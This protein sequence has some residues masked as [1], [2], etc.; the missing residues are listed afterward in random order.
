MIKI[1]VVISAFNEEKMIGDCLKSIGTLADEI[2]VVDN[3][4]SDNTAKIAKKYTKNIF[5]VPNDPVMLNKNKNYGFGKTTG[6]WILSLDADER[7]T[8]ELA[9]E[10]KKVTNNKGVNGFEIPRKNIIFGKWIQHSIWWPDYNLR[11]FRKNHGRFQERHVHEK[12]HVDGK[13]SKLQNPLIHYNYQTVSQFIKKM[14]NTY[15]ESEVTN[16]IKS[17]KSIY[18][19]D[20]IR[21]PLNDFLKTFF[22]QNGYRDG[23][24]GLV[25]SILQSFYSFIVFAKIWERKEDFKDITPNKFLESFIKEIKFGSKDL[26]YWIYTALIEESKFNKVIYKLKRKFR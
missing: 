7:V 12:L 16:F 8:P 5:T 9:K 23:M 6:Q 11:L 20:A 25:L 15:T 4:S 1:S 2:I 17:G 10:I 22:A 21:F 18:W 14:D 19:Y 13:I 26:K 3:T 24:H